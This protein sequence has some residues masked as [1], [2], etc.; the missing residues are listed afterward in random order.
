MNLSN[1]KNLLIYFCGIFFLF[2]FVFL[3]VFHK[4][5]KIPASLERRFP[6]MGTICSFRLIGEENTSP[7]ELAAAADKVQDTFYQIE[8]ICNIFDPGSELALLNEK[9]NSSPGVCSPRLWEILH[10][11]RYFYR[12]SSGAFDISILPLMRLWGFYRKRAV[13]PTEKE[14]REAKK[15]TGLDKVF[16]DDA[17]HTVFVPSPAKIRF[18]L[19]GIA[20]GYALDQAAECAAKYGIRRGLLDLGGNLR[21]LEKAPGRNKPYHIIGIRDPEGGN[22]SVENVVLPNNMSIATSGSYE[23][24]VFIGGKRYTHILDARTALPVSSGILS[25]TV[26]TG[27]GIHSDALSSCV[28]I[29]GEAFAKKVCR[30]FPDSSIL[31]YKEENGKIVRKSFGRAFQK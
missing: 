28:F 20:K 15:N 8:K 27:K 4:K 25:A 10:E 21:S 24:H 1:T 12:Y 19:G 7:E 18:D 29:L 11:A 2:L 22:F 13:L 23:R 5:E 30:D 6:V 9:M 16:F 3:F 14:I 26:L 17:R 31:I